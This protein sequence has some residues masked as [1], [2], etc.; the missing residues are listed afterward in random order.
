MGRG[1]LLELGSHAKLVAR[2]GAY[3]ALLAAQQAKGKDV[4]GPTDGGDGIPGRTA[5]QSWSL[6]ATLRRSV[7]DSQRRRASRRA[8]MSAATADVVE[9]F[10]SVSFARIGS[11]G[12][13]LGKDAYE[14][15][16]PEKV[17]ALLS[18]AFTAGTGQEDKEQPDPKASIA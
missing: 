11:E 18:G 1:S 3:A 7:A 2:G 12:M 10:N 15:A 4:M 17:D 9:T 6:A 5:Q 16:G 14:R 13:G 8:S